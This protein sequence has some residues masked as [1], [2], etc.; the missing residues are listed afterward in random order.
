M[1]RRDFLRMSKISASS[2]KTVWHRGRL[3]FRLADSQGRYRDY[4]ID[5]VYLMRLA[6]GLNRH[7]IPLTS[8]CDMVRR[9]WGSAQKCLDL[10]DGK[11]ESPVLKYLVVEYFPSAMHGYEWRPVVLDGHYLDFREAKQVAELMVEQPSHNSAETRV[12][13]AEIIH[14]EKDPKSWGESDA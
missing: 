1:N 13:V 3:P 2:F 12:V 8:A 11:E 6:V 5:E 10:L 9:D 7:G 4:T 14:V